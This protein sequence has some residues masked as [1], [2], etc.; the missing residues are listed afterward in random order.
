MM[1]RRNFIVG[2]A[3][4]IAVAPIVGKVVAS[5]KPKVARLNPAWVEA[6]YSVSFAVPEGF[7]RPDGLRLHYGLGIIPPLVFTPSSPI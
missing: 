4:A 5:K 2:A 3:A 7:I 1:T 6:P